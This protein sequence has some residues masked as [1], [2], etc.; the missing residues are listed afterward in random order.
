MQGK[1]CFDPDLEIPVNLD[2]FIPTKHFLRKVDRVV[3]LTFVR[4]LTSKY[5][6]HKNGRPSIDPEVFFRIALIG[7]FYGIQEDR[8]LC[9]EVQYNLAYRMKKLPI[10]LFTIQ[11]VI[12]TNAQQVNIYIHLQSTTKI[13]G[14]IQ[15][16]QK[17][18]L[19]VL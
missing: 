18:V 13:F 4:K 12:A 10:N 9:S 8:K 1:H 7:Y 16:N 3:D 5:Y 17:I 15:Q 14:Y 2:Q 11:N 19:T 6:C